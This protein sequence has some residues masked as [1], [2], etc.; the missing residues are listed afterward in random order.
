MPYLQCELPVEPYVLSKRMA[1]VLLG[2]PHCSANVETIEKRLYSWC[3][4]QDICLLPAR[5]NIQGRLE[6][7]SELFEQVA[8]DLWR[9]TDRA[10]E[11]LEASDE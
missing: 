9:L 11:L 8:P 7:Q 4:E 10:K 6:N 1:R 2:E 3:R 5:E